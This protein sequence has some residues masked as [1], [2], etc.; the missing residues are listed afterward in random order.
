MFPLPASPVF[1]VLW[2][3]SEHR[4]WWEWVDSTGLTPAQG[5][6]SGETISPEFVSELGHK[7]GVHLRKEPEAVGDFGLWSLR[8]R[9]RQKSSSRQAEL[10]WAD[11]H[12]DRSVRAA[13]IKSVN[14]PC[15]STAL[16]VTLMFYILSLKST[17]VPERLLFWHKQP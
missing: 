15:E 13:L 6:S 11:D 1:H 7:R 17:F 5:C 10:S 9:R 12:M 2:E 3:T 14:N 16:S 8:G 4:L